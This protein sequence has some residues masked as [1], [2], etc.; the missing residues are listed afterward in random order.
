MPVKVPNKLPAV[1]CLR[2]ENIFVIEEPRASSQDIRPLRIAVLNLMPLKIM[3]ETD[4]LRLISNTPLQVELDLIDTESHA[5]KNTPREHIEAFYKTFKEIRNRYY[6]GFIITGAPVEKVEFEAVDYWKE[7]TEIFDWAKTHVTSTL[8][9]CWAAFAGV[10]HN[11]GINKYIIED[12]ISGVF[13]HHILDLK[14]PIFRGFDDEFY[15]PHS[16]YSVWKREEIERVP[17]LKII[18]D[19]EDAGIYMIMARGGREFYIT[20][21]SEY[22]PMTLDFEYHR[23]LDKG[24]NPGIPKNYYTDDDPTKKPIVRWRGHAHL[25]FSNWLN[26]FVYQATPYDLNRIQYL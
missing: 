11:Y 26:Y 25:L 24:M 3:T 9:I 18:A 4:L 15:V 12:K 8:Y 2:N 17:E 20:G 23:D 1:E 16:R 10:Y 6:D 19:S 22:S 5:S 13:K 7:L 14:N 21:H